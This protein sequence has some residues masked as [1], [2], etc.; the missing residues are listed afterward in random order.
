VFTTA[1]ASS[2]ETEDHSILTAELN[3]LNSP[4]LAPHHSIYYTKA[5]AQSTVS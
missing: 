3:R 1:V 2:L 4:L 5:N